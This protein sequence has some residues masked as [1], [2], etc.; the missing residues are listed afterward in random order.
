MSETNDRCRGSRRAIASLLAAATLLAGAGGCSNAKQG[1]VSGAGI[2]ALSGLAI[3]S[4]TGSAGKGAAIGAV[5]GGVGGAVIGDQNRRKA[6]QAAAKPPPPAPP[7]PAGSSD[8]LTGQA[9]GRLVGN[10]RVAGTV[11]GA[12]GATLPVSGTVRA[13]ADKT[14]FVRMDIRTVDPRN[15]QTVEGTS[16]ISQRGGR[17]LDMTNSFSSS[18]EVKRFTGEMDESGSVFNFAQVDPPGSSRRIIIRA[19][20]GTQWT[21]DVW[22]GNRRVESYTFTPGT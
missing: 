21:A 3:G 8:Y 12:D 2:G 4:L 10:W 17:A 13:V 18:P 14:Y 5:V 16:V 9:L 19:S 22:D 6:E 15:G 1:A 11:E 7:P 20:N